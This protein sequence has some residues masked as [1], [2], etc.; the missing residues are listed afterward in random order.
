MQMESINILN[1]SGSINTSISND[2]WS[3]VLSYLKDITTEPV[4]PDQLI[5]IMK[6]SFV[7]KSL[8]YLITSNSFWVLYNSIEYE[9]AK[10][11]IY[12]WNEN[13]CR[14]ISKI[15]LP[16]P[17]NIIYMDN[18][19]YYDKSSI[20]GLRCKMG[21]IKDRFNISNKEIVHSNPLY[22]HNIYLID[23]SIKI[24]VTYENEYCML[25]EMYTSIKDYT[26]FIIKK[27]KQFICGCL[28]HEDCALCEIYNTVNLKNFIV[29]KEKQVV[30]D[31]INDSLDASNNKYNLY[32]NYIYNDPENGNLIQTCHNID[33]VL[34][35]NYIWLTTK[36]N[37]NSLIKYT[38]TNF[39]AQ[40]IM[41]DVKY[42]IHQIEE[43]QNEFTDNSF[44][45][46]RYYY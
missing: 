44:V 41:T 45:K 16:I 40:N 21:Y 36:I 34:H 28:L 26:K 35:D 17:E 4:K 11:N 33:A 29:D 15:R 31:I 3:T 39:Y 30:C 37:M 23:N 12:D 27:N 6:M 38:T 7:N 5:A 1:N 42:L 8:R 10:Y 20:F 24:Q 18:S 14:I 22:K 32:T 19:K 25:C 43:P 13:F 46:Q 9:S 2:I